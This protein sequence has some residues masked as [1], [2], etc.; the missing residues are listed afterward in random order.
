MG[1]RGRTSAKELEIAGPRPL[2]IVERL[3]APHD[4][5]DEEVE[6]WAAVAASKPADWFDAA[7]VP[8]LAQY[9]RHCVQARRIAE[10][11]ERATSA[12]D[13]DPNDYERLLRMQRGE[14]ASIAMLATKMRLTQ[15]STTNH[16]GNKTIR[17]SRQP[18]EFT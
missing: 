1:T 10:L 17:A 12:K 2:E 3:K 9:C 5:S 16:R 7:T 18:W 13:L 8:L 15:Q 4:L 6:V 11:L 14:S